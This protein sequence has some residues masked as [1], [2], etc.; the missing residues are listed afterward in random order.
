MQLRTVN[1]PQ[2]ARLGFLLIAA[3]MALLGAH[4]LVKIDQLAAHAELAGTDT[5]PFSSAFNGLLVAL[6][7]NLL[8]SLV[9]ARVLVTSLT[10][11]VV[12]ALG[13]AE[14][15]ANGDLL[16]P[17]TVDGAGEA[18]NAG[19]LL[20]AM[21]RM[22]ENLSDTLRQVRGSVSEVT[23]AAGAL[24]QAT[25]SSANSLMRQNS[26]IEQANQAFNTMSQA[27]QQVAHNTQSTR[28]ATQQATRSASEGRERV[29]E[30]VTAIEHMNEEVQATA[31][32]IGTLAEES[33]GIGKVLEVIGGLAHQT[34]L[35]ALNAAIEA[36]R[37]GESGRGFAVVADEV[38][39]LAERTRQSTEDIG[40]I[41]ATLQ[42]ASDQAVVSMR[43]NT[44]RSES[45]LG[46]ARHAGLALETIH[47]SMLQIDQR[48]L[49]IVAATQQQHRVAR[50]V[51]H[52][53]ANIHEL[54]RQS[55]QAGQQTRDASDQLADLAQRMNSAVARFSL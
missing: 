7:I 53:L 12:E 45:T 47:A 9:I 39:A 28:Q 52:N 5:E 55:A 4:A 29:R 11:T 15:I 27:A 18:G 32:L 10:H 3:L 23:A 49:L 8:L 25:A 34:N 51:D 19:R 44:D 21:A 42:A 20:K 40:R 16:R 24:N 14:A 46:I 17:I 2:R 38:R 37:A 31:T 1:M 54:S 50:E 48:N 36:A 41:V 43:K 26:E 33:R 35:L 6:V 22:R 30:T 13:A